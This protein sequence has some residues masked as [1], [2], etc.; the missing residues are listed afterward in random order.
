MQL[1]DFKKV[2]EY[3]SHLQNI[4]GGEY[5]TEMR[6]QISS[7]Y[8]RVHNMPDKHIAKILCVNRS[9]PWHYARCSPPRD[10]V[11]NTVAD[12]L[13]VWIEDKMYPKS[14][15]T[16]GDTMY[17]LVDDIH[18]PVRSENIERLKNWDDILRD[19]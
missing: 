17:K 1:D 7:Y 16:N 8:K 10:F 15:Y 4:R 5:I 18:K 13:L 19:L 2:K 11:R 3:F 14:F 6:R 9:A 12:N